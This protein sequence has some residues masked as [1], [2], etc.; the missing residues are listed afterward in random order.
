MDE[1][2]VESDASE[3]MEESQ[4]A[5][6]VIDLTEFDKNN[7]NNA[8]IQS[9]IP[10][11]CK[12]EPCCFGIDEAGRGPVLGP[13]VYGTSFCPISWNTQL[14]ELGFAD[15]KTLNEGQRE[16]LM[17]SIQDASDYMGYKVEILSPNYIANS[18]LRRNKHSLNAVSMDSAIGLLRLA[19][20][21]GVQVKEVYV[22]TVGDAKKY[23]DKLKGLFPDLDITVCPKADSKFPI[24]SAASI[25]AKVTR[26]RAT[27]GWKFV[28][29][30]D[31]DKENYGSGYPSDPATKKW[32]AGNVDPVFGFSQ[33]VRFSWSTSSLILDDHAFPVQW[34]DDDEEEEAAKGTASLLSFFAP[35]NAD[36]RQKKHQFFNER[37]LKQVTAM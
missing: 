3:A 5:A 12:D 18:M 24:V 23:Q 22:D 33:F 20:A 6:A 17:K 16:A 9:K 14:G 29:T 1:K 15:S 35:K 28:E 13:M 19:L 30:N 8:I 37:D 34:E 32:L 4:D 7:S 31:F 2:E 27:T 26:D 11:I 10:Q 21:D 25:C 36:A